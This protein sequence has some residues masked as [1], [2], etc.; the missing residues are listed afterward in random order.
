MA[1]LVPWGSHWQV[2]REAKSLVQ[3][4]TAPTKRTQSLNLGSQTPASYP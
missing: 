3:G 4:H 2:H 1:H